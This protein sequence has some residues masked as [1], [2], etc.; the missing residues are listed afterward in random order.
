VF[1]LKEAMRPALCLIGSAFI[2]MAYTGSD[3]AGKTAL[4]T[5]IVFGAFTAWF[6]YFGARYSRGQK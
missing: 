1:A 6:W 5:E 2:V 3:E 4:A